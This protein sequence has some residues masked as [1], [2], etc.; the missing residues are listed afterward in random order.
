M[1]PG[2]QPLE[3][4]EVLRDRSRIAVE[5]PL[6]GRLEGLADGVGY[7]LVRD[8]RGSDRACI[9]GMTV[10]RP[11]DRGWSP[12]PTALAAG[13]ALGEGEQWCDTVPGAEGGATIAAG[14]PLDALRLA[15]QYA[16]A[17][18]VIVGSG[19]VLAEGMGTAGH[20]WQ[21]EDPAGWPQLRELWPD[22]LDEL[23]RVRRRWQAMEVLSSRA[24][25]LP[26]MVSRS[27]TP[28]L[29]QA[30]VL[31]ER[32]GSGAHPAAAILTSRRGAQRLRRAGADPRRI[33]LIDLSPPGANAETMALEQVPALLRSRL[34]VRIAEHDGGRTVMAAFA[35]AGALDQLHLTLMRGRSLRTVLAKD[36]PDGE[37]PAAS[38]STFFPG[39]GRLPPAL[40]P[41]SLLAGSGEALIACLDARAWDG[42]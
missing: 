40:A 35:A 41:V 10:L 17:D 2:M 26:V 42:S 4:C 33:E 28:E 27:G 6:G 30:R 39:D 8:P 18:A 9:V 31:Q 15:F 25:P 13:T 7:P 22:L 20:R 12:S 38:A 19:T 36:S 5:L 16:L 21:P 23:A 34:D 1:E 29:L 14:D 32:E 37:D 11:R 3:Q 24:R